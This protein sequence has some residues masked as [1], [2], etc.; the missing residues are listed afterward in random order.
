ML[1]SCNLGSKRD[2][3]KCVY[4]EDSALMLV[5]RCTVIARR[6]VGVVVIMTVG[7][8][9]HM[10][11]GVHIQRHSVDG[12]KVLARQIVSMRRLGGGSPGPDKRCG[13]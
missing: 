5:R 12:V 9:R 3:T 11:V 13:N 8:S 6:L 4:V 10:V 2:E 7:I 1:E